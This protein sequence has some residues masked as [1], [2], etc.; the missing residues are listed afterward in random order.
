MGSP[1]LQKLQDP[2]LLSMFWLCFSKPLVF[3]FQAA[4][5]GRADTSSARFPA[6]VERAEPYQP[7]ETP[8]L[9]EAMVG[10]PARCLQRPQHT[11]FWHRLIR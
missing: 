8:R 4:G 9:G 3:R 10:G 7:P 5:D 1:T 11:D 2:I 6:P